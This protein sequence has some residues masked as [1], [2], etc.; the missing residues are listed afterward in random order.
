MGLQLLSQ[1]QLAREAFGA[2]YQAQWRVME[3]HLNQQQCEKLHHSI[4]FQGKPWVFHIYVGLSMLV[5]NPPR[6]DGWKIPIFMVVIHIHCFLNTAIDHFSRFGFWPHVIS[7]LGY[8]FMKFMVHPFSKTPKYH[9]GLVLL[10]KSTPETIDFPR[11]SWVFPVSIFPT[12][13]IHISIYL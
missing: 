5:V 6:T 11:R 9:P 13:P 3:Y 1:A 7:S 8:I 12:T 2:S 10:G 4:I